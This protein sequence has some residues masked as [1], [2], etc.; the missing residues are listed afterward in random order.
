MAYNIL[1]VDDSETIRA[2]LLKTIN[3]SGIEVNQLFEAENGQIALDM[4]ENNWIDIVFADINM[5]V[6]SGIEMVDHMHKTGQ[7]NSTPVVI[8]STEGSQTRVEEL[9]SK[10]VRAFV[11]K[12]VTPEIFKDTVIDVLGDNSQL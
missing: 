5:P 6:M 11:R 4:L 7:I 8:V 10:G 1:I 12:P 2:V 9:M 3:M